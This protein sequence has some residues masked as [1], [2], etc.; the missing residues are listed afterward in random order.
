MSC[1]VASEDDHFSDAS[2]GHPQSDS[3]PSSRLPS[4]V[5]RTRVEKVDS[6]P[7]HGEVPG[8]PAYNKREHDAI[9]DEIEIVPEGSQSRRLSSAEGAR[10]PGGSPIPRTQVTKV[11]STTP[12]HGEVAGT[13]AYEKRRADAVPDLVLK[14]PED[15]QRPI[16]QDGDASETPVPGTLLSRVDTLPEDPSS[17]GLRAHRRRP[18]D[19]MPDTT[20]T[21]RDTT[22]K[23]ALY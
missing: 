5:P 17:P 3:G 23:P 11:D 2:E 15:R 4:P 7:S 9:P 14:V 13:D 10:T 16:P 19:A 1:H 22:G 18:S 6:E 20:E 8:T 21:M 12:R